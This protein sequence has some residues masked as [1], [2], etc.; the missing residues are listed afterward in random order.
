MTAFVQG[1]LECNLLSG[2]FKTLVTEGSQIHQSG[3]VVNDLIPLK[4]TWS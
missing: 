2:C 4:L 3:F 1:A